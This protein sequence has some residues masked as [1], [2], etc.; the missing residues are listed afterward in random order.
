MPISRSFPP[1]VSVAVFRVRTHVRQYPQFN[2]DEI[3]DGSDELV[4]RFQ[5]FLTI[6]GTQLHFLNPFPDTASYITR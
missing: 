6:V 5:Q 1:W 2:F 4:Q 3:I